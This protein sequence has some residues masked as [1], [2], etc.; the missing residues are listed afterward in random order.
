MND[1]SVTARRAF[2]V[3]AIFVGTAALAYGLWKV[4]VII[5]LLFLGVI[6]AAAMRP[7]VEFMAR[8]RI[9]R[10]IGVIVHYLFFAGLIALFLWQVVPVITDQVTAAVHATSKGNLQHSV[11]HSNG[12]K[13]QVLV[14]IQNKLKHL[15]SGTSLIHPAINLTLR[16]F[17]VF[18]GIFFTFA[19]AAYWVFERERAMALVL[20]LVSKE[21]R[22]TVRDTWDLIDLKLGAFVRGQSILICFVAIALSILFWLIGEPYWLLIGI[23]SGLVEIVPV[24]GPIAA[25]ALAVGVGFTASFHIALLAGLCVLGVRLFQDYIISPRVLGHAVGLS[26]LLVM[27]AATTVPLLFG[28]FYVI[29]ALPILAVLATLV[30]VVVLDKDP[31]EEEVPK[32]L[33]PAQDGET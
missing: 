14:G 30:D 2:L 23:F 33:F 27:V 19:A 25:G 16:V 17:E 24:V 15:P 20:R 26:P 21:K 10:P 1:W 8:Y 6:I 28:A 4:R 32:L 7:G 31:A 5:A 18:I 3:S 9:P 29:L 22:K 13:H 12:I 11:S